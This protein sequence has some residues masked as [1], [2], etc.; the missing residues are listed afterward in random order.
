MLEQIKNVFSGKYN[1]FHI[2][3]Y[4]ST[5]VMIVQFI[6]LITNEVK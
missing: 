1:L 3:N 6:K 5:H 2:H 4:I